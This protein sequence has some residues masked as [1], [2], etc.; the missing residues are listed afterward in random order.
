MSKYILILALLLNACGRN[1]DTADKALFSSWTRTSDSSVLDLTGGS[2]GAALNLYVSGSGGQVCN[3]VITITGSESSG[4]ASI[5]Y[6]SGRP[7]YCPAIDLNYT[8]TKFSTTLV[9][10]TSG[11]CGEYR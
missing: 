10:C 5:V 1:E 9:V 7:G 3:P 2:F 4:T 8:Y 11:S 6:P